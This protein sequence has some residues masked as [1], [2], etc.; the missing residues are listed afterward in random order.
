MGLEE[1]QS[2]RSAF[3]RPVCAS[4]CWQGQ[5]HVATWGCSVISRKL[6][7]SSRQEAEAMTDLLTGREKSK[8]SWLP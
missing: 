1:G 5:P 6:S 2:A 8:V 3:C 4:A 7:A